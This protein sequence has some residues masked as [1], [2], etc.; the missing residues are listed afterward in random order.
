MNKQCPSIANALT[1]E[2]GLIDYNSLSISDYNK[3]YIA[4]LKLAF[5]YYMKI[6]LS[7]L[8]EGI[9]SVSLPLSEI[10]MIDYG[11]GTGFLSMLAKRIG[12]GR[13]IYIDLNPKSVETIT[14]LKEKTG[15]GPDDILCGNSHDLANWCKLKN[16]NPQLLIATD[17]IEHVYSLDNFFDDL[18]GINSQLCM[19]FS[20][21][22]NPYNFY[23]KRRLQKRMIACEQGNAE[24]PNYL[25]L[26]SKFIF[27]NFPQLSTDEQQRWA[28][29]TRGL[30][31][32]DIKKAIET[33]TLP[34]V[35][36]Y[37][38]CDPRTGNWEER[39]LSFSEYRRLLSPYEYTLSVK[40]GYYN[41]KRSRKVLS[42]IVACL[43][44]FIGLI[45]EAGLLVSPF[46][47]LVCRK[48]S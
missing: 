3:R 19:I 29:N 12:I 46:I 1:D 42:A 25:T 39:I 18:I 48:K 22:S 45:G 31:F 26:R 28:I 27:E 36:A 8:H 41:A 40:K 33:N 11:G 10:T 6:Y 2:L 13:V 37:N 7:C 47:I 9:K 20:T 15:N 35:D 34:T 38:T 44:V 32:E 30:I 5:P 21:G 24:I 43:N 23:T 4:N 16:V 17:L 14:L